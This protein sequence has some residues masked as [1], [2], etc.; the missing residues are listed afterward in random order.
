[1]IVFTIRIVVQD[2]VE[3]SQSQGNQFPTLCIMYL[4]TCHA[5]GKGSNPGQDQE[6]FLFQKNS[7]MGG[8]KRG[9][10]EKP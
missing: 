6:F 4:Q 5:G 7:D 1:M 9:I 10:M 2:A 3:Q 8:K